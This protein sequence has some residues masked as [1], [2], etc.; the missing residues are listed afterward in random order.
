MYE[1]LS[2]QSPAAVF[3][4]LLEQEAQQS[5]AGGEG[6]SGGGGSGSDS[7]V[8]PHSTNDEVGAAA[9]LVA[10]H[11]HT[12]EMMPRPAVNAHDDH[13]S[14]IVAAETRPAVFDHII[15]LAT[16]LETVA[17]SEATAPGG[18][19]AP[20]AALSAATRGDAEFVA[21][22]S[23]THE[24]RRGLVLGGMSMGGREARALVVALLQRDPRQRL[25]ASRVLQHETFIAEAPRQPSARFLRLL[26][27]EAVRGGGTR[28]MLGA[29]L[30]C[31]RMAATWCS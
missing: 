10:L 20:L 30:F 22:G 7:M 12:D 13:Y 26:Q 5:R 21:R 3:G 1:C 4:S 19:S 6:R 14:H 29:P 9:A 15:G 28:T 2:G 27:P 24:R 16:V 11:D 25:P 18:G 8:L 31:P 17:A 23:L